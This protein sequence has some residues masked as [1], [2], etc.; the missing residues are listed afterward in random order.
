MENVSPI[1]SHVGNKI[2]ICTFLTQIP[3]SAITKN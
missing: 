1:L 3:Q 2:D